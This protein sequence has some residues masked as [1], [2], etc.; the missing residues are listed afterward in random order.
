M[1]GKIRKAVLL[2]IVMVLL[3]G[4]M[5]VPAGAAVRKLRNQA[6]T[7]VRLK[8]DAKAFAVNTGTT[9]VKLP[10]KGRGYLKFTAP[11]DGEYAFTLSGLKAKIKKVKVT[12]KKGT[13]KK[14]KVRPFS[15]GYFYV[16]TASAD[17][18]RIGQTPLETS[19]GTTNTLWLGT[20]LTQFGNQ[21]SWRLTKR[22]GK[23]A[24]V[25]NQTVYL[26]FSFN[27]GDRVKLRIDRAI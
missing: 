13:V 8:A 10:S 20:K 2:V 16:M 1:R 21:V 11:A 5:A 22:I 4:I 7:R 6:F 24:L 17:G 15:N 23:T 3:F 27:K 26:Y 18:E 14:K 12:T 9:T 19:G 25:R